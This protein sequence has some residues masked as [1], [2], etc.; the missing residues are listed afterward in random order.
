MPLDVTKSSP[1]NLVAENGSLSDEL[2]KFR[3][4]LCPG[5]DKEPG[6]C[7]LCKGPASPMHGALRPSLTRQLD[8]QSLW[9]LPGVQGRAL[10]EAF[11][12]TSL[13]LQH[14]ERAS[15]WR[16]AKVWLADCYGH[17]PNFARALHRTIRR[18]ETNIFWFVKV[19]SKL[20]EGQRTCQDCGEGG[21]NQP[22]D[23]GLPSAFIKSSPLC[24]IILWVRWNRLLL[25]LLSNED[26][27]GPQG[28]RTGNTK[29]MAFTCLLGHK[30]YVGSLYA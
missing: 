22:L 27:D 10:L 12:S 17:L 5:E 14:R 29:S 23:G 3:F 19:K 15:V 4:W 2:A 25:P 9:P 13:N 20:I 26:T 21:G 8:S 1:Q 28:P 11:G 18:C 30:I 7:W 16:Y 24:S 6:L